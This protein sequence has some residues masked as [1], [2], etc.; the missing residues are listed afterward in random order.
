MYA[1]ILAGGSGTRLWPLSRTQFPKQ[2]IDFT[3]NGRSLFQET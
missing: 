1:V 3:D 2:F